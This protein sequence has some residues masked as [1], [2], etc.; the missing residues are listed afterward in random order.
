MGVLADMVVCAYTHCKWMVFAEVMSREKAA[1]VS[2]NDEITCQNTLLKPKN[3]ESRRQL[4]ECRGRLHQS[5]RA[6]RER[7]RLEQDLSQS[8]S[9][10]VVRASGK[11]RGS[12]YQQQYQQ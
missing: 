6:A 11:M 10:S 5:E 12:K 3:N 4:K 2:D 8:T 7:Y 9:I 1:L